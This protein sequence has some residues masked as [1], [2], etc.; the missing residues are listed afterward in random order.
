[1][2]HVLILTRTA[3]TL[4]SCMLC[5]VKHEGS[6][7]GDKMNGW[8]EY[9][10]HRTINRVYIPLFHARKT[11]RQCGC[12]MFSYHVLKGLAPFSKSSFEG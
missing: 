1:M 10:K 12:W 3:D 5:K 11:P 9:S 7:L 6:L 4:R 2:L 8:F